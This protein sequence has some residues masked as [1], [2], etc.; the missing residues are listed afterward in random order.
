MK[1]K[2]QKLSFILLLIACFFTNCSVDSNNKH[3]IL[4]FD[5]F[6]ITTNLSHEKIETNP[7]L[8]CVV[9]L[10]L[11]D[12]FL[13]TI[14]LKAD[15]F[16]QILKLPAF[17]CK[18]GFIT[19]GPGPEEEIFIEPYIARISN[20]EF[21]FKGQTS[22]KIAE[23]NTA[24]NKLEI[25]TKI[26]LPHNLIEMWNIMKLGDSIIGNKMLG[27]NWVNKEFIGYNLKDN[28]IFDFGEDYPS[29]GRKIDPQRKDNIFSKISIIKPDGSAIASVYDKFPILRIY[30]ITGEIKKEVRLN[31]GQPF[32]RALL[33]N[34]PSEYSLNERIQNYRM[35][36]ASNN[37]I[38]ALYVGKKEQEMEKGVN[39]LS[40][41]I[42][43][44]NWDGAP[45]KRFLLDEKIFTFDVDLNDNYLIA[46]SL[47]SIDAL[48]KYNL[49]N[50]Y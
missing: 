2:V 22:I 30:S 21:L 28:K 23:Y 47:L 33:E 32:P 27:G 13:V 26:N 1:I 41:E 9:G 50:H 31:N 40:N 15:T 12:S 7:N 36:K 18:G 14:D 19:R 43:I 16:F 44:W 5:K 4:T 20:K 39:D 38:Y 3:E 6:P 49:K 11:L 45:I 48:Y 17:D 29:V 42:H 37:Y 24:S 34:N 46:Y 8:Y 25:V 35:I 10:L